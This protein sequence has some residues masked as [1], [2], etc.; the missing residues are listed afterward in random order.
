[1]SDTPTP[2]TATDR[3]PAPNTAEAA[4]LY[5]R[6]RG[7]LGVLKLADAAEAMPAALDQAAAEELSMTA[8]LERLLSIEVAATEARWLAGRLQFACLPTPATLED[9]ISTTPPGSER[10]ICRSGWRGLQRMLGIGRI[11]PPPPISPLDVIGLRSKADGR[12]RCG[13]TPGRHCW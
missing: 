7:H 2:R 3:L 8:A 4:S 9:S 1:M 12:R 11:S 13:S 10:S 5:Q 6:L